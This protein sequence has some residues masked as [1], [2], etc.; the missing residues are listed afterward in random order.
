MILYV[1]VVLPCL[2]FYLVY[3]LLCI[4]FRRRLQLEQRLKEIR[5]LE[6]EEQPLLDERLRLPFSQR[7]FYPMLKAC[8]ERL[9]QF[10]P[11]AM[12]GATERKLTMAGIRLTVEQWS[13]WYVLASVGGL[14]L[15]VLLGGL[16]RP[17]FSGNLLGGVGGLLLGAYMP[18]LLL[19]QTIAKRQKV[20]LRSLPDVLDLLTVSV[21]AGLGFDSAMQRVIEKMKGPLPEE[22]AK[23]LH[24]V[25][26]GVLRKDAL[27]ALAERTGVAELHGFVSTIIQA[28]QLGVSISNVLQL[29]SES[30]RQRRSQAA[31]EQAMKAP[32][33]MLFPL[34]MF[35]FPTLFIVL[36][37]PAVIQ[38]LENF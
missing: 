30:L 33:K 26:V 27:K 18:R 19:S 21:K 22:L 8:G 6:A 23:V 15:G 17:G 35:I 5:Q 24:E 10:A 38:F 32:V 2:V 25:K 34:V 12:R 20:I 9:Q 28:D 16:L 29:Q 4:I 7:V 14:L 36:L 3:G 13:G 1:S 11:S 31:E 37:G